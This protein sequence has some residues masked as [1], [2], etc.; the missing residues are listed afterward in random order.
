MSFNN[1]NMIKTMTNAKPV[2]A[3]K[4]KFTQEE[5]LQ[6]VKLILSQKEPDWSWIASQMPNRNPRQCRERWANYLNPNLH[7]GEWTEEEDNIILEK[8]NVHGQKWSI[9]ASYL[10]G[11]SGNDV[12]N[13]WLML[14]RHSQKKK[15]QKAKELKRFAAT[16]QTNQN[17][18]K[19]FIT[20]HINPIQT[21]ANIESLQTTEKPKVRVESVQETKKLIFAPIFTLAPDLQ[22]YQFVF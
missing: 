13:R 12:R 1:A 9:I 6:L 17:K 21:S 8:K 3:C 5:D 2:R 7:K 14:M 18:G 19:P 10:N 11:R 20:P 16:I 15:N 4:S 22:Y